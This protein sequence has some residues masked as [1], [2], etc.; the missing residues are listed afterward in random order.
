M[1][2]IL[3]TSSLDLSFGH[4]LT[5][6]FLAFGWVRRIPLLLHPVIGIPLR[7]PTQN[8][9]SGGEGFDSRNIRGSGPA[10][11]GASLRHH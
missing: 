11:G 5:F 10:P 7:E 1:L 6:F 3:E 8:V 4:L 2:E 9:G